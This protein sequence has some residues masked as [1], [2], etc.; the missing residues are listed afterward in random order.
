MFAVHTGIGRA[1]VVALALAAATACGSSETNGSGWPGEPAE[2]YGGDLPAVEPATQGAAVRQDS[3]QFSRVFP[4]VAP[5]DRAA[6]GGKGDG[7]IPAW[8]NARTNEG[9]CVW[10]H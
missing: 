1:S 4:R 5:L 8:C 9:K 2:P 10:S 7:A 6:D 3:P